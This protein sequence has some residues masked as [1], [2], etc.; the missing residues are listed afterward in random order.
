MQIKL[1]KVLAVL[2]AAA[3]MGGMTLSVYSE[4]A[5]ET[6]ETAAEEEV[7]TKD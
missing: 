6:E 5:A 1:R 7:E 4:D 3:T 2:A